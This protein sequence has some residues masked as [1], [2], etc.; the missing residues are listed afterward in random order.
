MTLPPPEQP[1]MNC[2]LVGILEEN[3][4]NINQNLRPNSPMHTLKPYTLHSK[5]TWRC[6]LFLIT[7]CEFI[8]IHI[9]LSRPR[10]SFAQRNTRWLFWFLRPARLT[11]QLQATELAQSTAWR[12]RKLMRQK[13]TNSWALSCKTRCPFPYTTLFGTSTTS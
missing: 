12:F 3:G 11:S 10:L 2:T 9:Y 5:A 13:V 4:D 7:Q 1:W 6:N 8:P